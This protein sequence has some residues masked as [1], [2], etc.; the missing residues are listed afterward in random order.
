MIACLLIVQDLVFKILQK[1]C[2]NAMKIRSFDHKKF[3]NKNIIQTY[4][5]KKTENVINNI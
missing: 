2:E 4:I 3:A 5:K 1:A